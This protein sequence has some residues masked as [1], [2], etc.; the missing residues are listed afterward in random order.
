MNKILSLA[1]VMIMAAA[2]TAWAGWWHCKSCEKGMDQV[3]IVN[4][5]GLATLMNAKTPLVLLD[6]RT[7]KYDDG[8]RIPGALTLGPAATNEEIAKVVPEKN[9]LIVTYCVNPK[10]MA[11]HHLAMRLR[12]AGYLNVLRYPA[13]IEGWVEAGHQVVEAKK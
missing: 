5:A 7:G 8:K 3:G 6:A 2:G 10:C 1:A 11:S 9:A 13:G 4:T 12:E